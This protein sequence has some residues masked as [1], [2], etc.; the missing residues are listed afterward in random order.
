VD[1]Q[2]QKILLEAS[3]SN[4]TR[5]IFWFLDSKLVF[6]GSAT[7][8]VFIDP[9]PGRHTL[10]CMDEEGRSTEMTLLIK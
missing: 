3:V 8:K 5:K 4:D 9:V 7:Q 2:Y 10:T 1:T 6:H